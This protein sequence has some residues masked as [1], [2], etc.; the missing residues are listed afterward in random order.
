MPGWGP[1]TTE[2]EIALAG[3]RSLLAAP[4]QSHERW[5]CGALRL[6]GDILYTNVTKVSDFTRVKHQVG[7][8]VTSFGRSA[9][10][11]PREQSL[12]GKPAIGIRAAP[13]ETIPIQ[14][15]IQLPCFQASH[16]ACV[17]NGFAIFGQDPARD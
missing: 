3:Q 2:Q 12:D 9:Q 17:G 5:E 16:Y 8:Q 11:D 7:E 1:G 6:F 10:F 15:H 4:A 14:S 13:E